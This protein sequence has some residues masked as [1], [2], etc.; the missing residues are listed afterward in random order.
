MYRGRIDSVPG[1][2]NVMAE[3]LEGRSPTIAVKLDIRG[4]M[5]H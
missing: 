1:V 5:Q 3:Y 4:G 2:G